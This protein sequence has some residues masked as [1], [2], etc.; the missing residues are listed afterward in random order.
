MPGQLIS[1]GENIWL[2]RI[3][4][5]RDPVSGKRNYHNKTVHGTKKDAERYLTAALRERDLGTFAEPSREL[6]NHYLSKWLKTAAKPKLKAATLYDY[7][8]LLRRYVIPELGNRPLA[9][10]TP[11]EIQ[12]LYTKMQEPVSGEERG[13]SARTVRYT[14][15]VLRSALQ[16]AVKWRLMPQNPADDVEL[17]KQARTEMQVFDPQQARRFLDS[18][19]DDRL[20]ALFAIAVTAG[21]RPSEYSALKWPDINSTSGTVSVSRTLEWL[22]GGGWRFADT[23]R[24]GSRRT[25]RL[26]RHVLEMLRK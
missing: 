17:P 22:H 7:T 1:R 25:V 12:S 10:I 21:L 18:A 4:L 2:V 6:L 23:K 13:L 15:A 11:L 19:E 9:K 24:A 5:G 8:K 16:Q 3:Y 26:Q 14:H 20:G